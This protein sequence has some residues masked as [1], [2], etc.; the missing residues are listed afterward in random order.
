M[1]ILRRV[2]DGAVR[3]HRS[4]DGVAAVRY[5]KQLRFVHVEPRTIRAHSGCNVVEARS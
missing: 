5:I 1:K 3:S 2:A 4:V